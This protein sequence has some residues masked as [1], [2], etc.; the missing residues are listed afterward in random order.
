M[1]DSIMLGVIGLG[2]VALAVS[3]IE[4]ALANKKKLKAETR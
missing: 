2:I 1:L 3:F 4:Y